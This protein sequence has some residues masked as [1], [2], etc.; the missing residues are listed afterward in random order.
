MIKKGLKIPKQ[1]APLLKHSDDDVYHTLK[2]YFEKANEL[3]RSTQTM[4]RP[5]SPKP[6]FTQTTMNR[7]YPPREKTA[8]EQKK[9]TMMFNSIEKFSERLIIIFFNKHKAWTNDKMILF[10]HWKSISEEDRV[11]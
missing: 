10:D 4:K 8:E 9:D 2:Y 5:E 6:K 7:L 1:I 3:A 11:Y